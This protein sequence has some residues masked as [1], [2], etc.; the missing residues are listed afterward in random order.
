M[1]QFALYKAVG[2]AVGRLCGC[3]CGS[4]LW[5][6]LWVREYVTG[7]EIA[8]FYVSRPLVSA[9]LRRISSRIHF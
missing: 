9:I 5:L 4:V 3:G 1:K 7:H 2:V 8:E 6:W